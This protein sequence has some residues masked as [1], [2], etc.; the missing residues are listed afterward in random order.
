MLEI[1]RGAE[2]V[3]LGADELAREH[4][5]EETP[6]VAA[7]GVASGGSAAV[8]GGSQLKESAAWPRPCAGWQGAGIARVLNS[9]DGADQV[10]L[11][12]PQLKQAAAMGFGDG[13]AGSTHVEEDAAI[14]KQ[15]G[16][17]MVGQIFFDGFKLRGEVARQTAPDASCRWVGAPRPE[18]FITSPSRAQAR[19]V[20]D[21]VTRVPLVDCE[22][23]LRALIRPR[24]GWLKPFWKSS[25][26]MD[27]RSATQRSCRPVT[28]VRDGSIGTGGCRADAP[29]RLRRRA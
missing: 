15:C 17:W 20:G 6:V 3:D 10:A 19:D 7:G 13:V 23:W 29:R 16:G 5:L 4:A 1:H 2:A 22:H 26:D 21:V 28:K 11:F 12:A 18:D 27:S 9:D 14:F 25:F 24:S 8:A